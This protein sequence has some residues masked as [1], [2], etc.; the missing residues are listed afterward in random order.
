MK[1]RNKVVIASA[2]LL[3]VTMSILSLQQITTV[4]SQIKKQINNSVNEILSSISS[5]VKSEIE[6]KKNLAQSITE[7]IEND[8]TN[9]NYVQTIID[10]SQLK[11]SFLSIGLG[12]ESNGKVV[13]NDVNWNIASDYDPRVRSWY[14]EAKNQ[15]K[16]IITEPY[17]EAASNKMIISVGT[18]VKYENKFIASIFYDVDL[19]KLSDLVNEVDIF[20]AGYLLLLTDDGKTIAHP[21]KEKNGMKL[22]NYFPNVE[23]KE[24]IQNVEINNVSYIIN[25][26]YIP[27]EKWY[28][29][30]VINE[31]I[32]YNAIGELRNNAIIY[33]LIAVIISLLALTLLIRIL[34]K[35]LD[36]LNT[37]IQKIASGNGD[38]TQRLS[39]NTDV[40]FSELAQGFN[41]F[42]SNLQKQT[43]DS[44]YIAHQISH[45]TQ[46]TRESAQ[47]STS[48][49]KA[50]LL[51]LEQLATAMNEMS[52]T[53]IEVANNAQSAAGT[54]KEVE[55]SVQQGSLVVNESTQ[56]IN[57]LSDSIDQSVKEVYNLESITANIETILKVINDIASQTN[58]LALNAAIEAAR[59]GE[60]GRGFAVVADEVRTLAQRTQKSTTEI[61]DM[62]EL[63]QSSTTLVAC[64]MKQSKVNAV[65]AVEKAQ[66]ANMSLDCISHAIGRITDVN[67]Q[68]ASAAE[69]QS[70]VSEEINN[71]AVNIKDL[72]TQVVDAAISTDD[73]MR[74]QSEHVNKQ[75]EILSKFK[76]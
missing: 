41:S 25:I 69:E 68:I 19:T 14:I 45:N 72:S 1:F 54:A 73:Y 55:K 58:L 26:V 4:R 9:S 33:S 62:I 50:Q 56:A 31:N 20:G 12:Y 52:V 65:E 5:T 28:L 36:G 27:S 16:P 8:P 11:K 22:S 64:A 2:F 30:A 3:F 44:K 61:R 29:A 74:T 15:N 70:L 63:L 57:L 21:D 67:L 13:K 18:P 47:N 38:L 6:S 71:N 51:E 42:I 75:E 43:I 35:P 17:V 60:S 39:T 48:A 37:A 34:M 7:V 76:V 59:A 66:Q 32:A 53:A 23:L 40:E 49:M 46:L 24:G 10:K